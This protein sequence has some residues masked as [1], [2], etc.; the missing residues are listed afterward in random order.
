MK[1]S[2]V[3][4][5]GNGV[6]SPL[7]SDLELVALSDSP[8]QSIKDAIPNSFLEADDL[9]GEIL[10]DVQCLPLCNGVCTNDRVLVLLALC[11]VIQFSILMDRL[12]IVSIGSLLKQPFERSAFSAC[13]R[14]LCLASRVS[15]KDLNLGDRA[16]DKIH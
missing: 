11:S 6:L 12:T 15:R 16:I 3:I 1:S 4:P 7:P 8:I 9:L 14:P 13:S 5:D 2:P 10:V